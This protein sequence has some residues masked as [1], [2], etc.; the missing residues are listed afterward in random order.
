MGI[1]FG[2][3]LSS[4][5]SCSEM[6]DAPLIQDAGSPSPA[7]TYTFFTLLIS[8]GVGHAAVLLT[9]V[10]STRVHRQATWINFCATWII[11]SLSYIL[12][13]L[14]GQATGPPPNVALCVTQSALTYGAPVL[15][16]YSALSLILQLVFNIYTALYQ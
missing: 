11:Y 15:T 7:V 3:I 1:L 9:M 13:M 12:L 6:P 10:L 2:L 14:F 8:G 16:A 4:F 5:S